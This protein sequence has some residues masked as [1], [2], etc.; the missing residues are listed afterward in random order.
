MSGI[1]A[2]ALF[3]RKTKHKGHHTTKAIPLRFR[4]NMLRLCA[5]GWSG[6]PASLPPGLDGRARRHQRPAAPVAFAPAAMRPGLQS[7]G[8]NLTA[9]PLVSPAE[10]GSR[11]AA[12]GGWPLTGRAPPVMTTRRATCARATRASAS[13]AR[14]DSSGTRLRA[15]ARADRSDVIVHVESG[16]A[17]PGRWRG[18]LSCGTQGQRYSAQVNG[19]CARTTSSSSSDT[20]SVRAEVAE[21]RTCATNGRSSR[22]TRGS[23]ARRASAPLRTT[24]AKESEGVRRN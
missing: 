16:R 8:T 22:S 23:A 19:R 20:S 11:P 15:R 18:M 17:L 21:R 12:A 4:R 9:R 5:A 10:P 13:F 6:F 24:A 7:N 3:L 2:F 14:V 1:A